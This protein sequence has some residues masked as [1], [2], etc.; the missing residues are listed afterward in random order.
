M[1]TGHFVPV[2]IVVREH[3]AGNLNRFIRER[4]RYSGFEDMRGPCSILNLFPIVAFIEP[5]A[6]FFNRNTL[7]RERL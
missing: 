5:L 3:Y 4:M 6:H 7:D 1:N 2:L